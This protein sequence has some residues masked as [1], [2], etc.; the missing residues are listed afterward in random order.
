[1]RRSILS[2][3]FDIIARAYAPARKFLERIFF[4]K[5]AAPGLLQVF[6]AN[7]TGCK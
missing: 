2:E 5:K 6:L 7:K 1:M 3:K 4:A